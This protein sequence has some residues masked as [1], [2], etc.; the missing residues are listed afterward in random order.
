MKTFTVGRNGE[1]DFDTIN[2]AMERIRMEHK[3]QIQASGLS[4]YHIELMPG[5]YEEKI[6]VDVPGVSI[7]GIDAAATVITYGDYA[8]MLLPDGKPYGTFRTATFKVDADDFM[9]ENITFV[10][11]AGNG[12]DF[13]QAVAVH[14]QG[15]RVIFRNCR[16]LAHQDTLYSGPRMPENE[17]SIP[18]ARQYFYKC[19]IAGDV[20]FIFGASTAFFEECEIFSGYGIIEDEAKIPEKGPD[21]QICGY[22]TATRTPEGEKYGFVFSRCRFTSDCPERTVYLGRPWRNFAKTVLTDCVLGNHIKPEG[23][24]DWN[25]LDARKTTF[26]AEYNSMADVSQRADWTHILSDAEAEEYKREAVL[27]GWDIKK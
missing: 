19:Y 17:D 16:M 7:A 3:S 1:Y 2:A 13:G 4:H 18:V 12:R 11:S 9:A 6:L 21:D 10:N 20:D 24:H 5:T 14:A 26:Y 27:A 23:W 8:R 22:V 25:K 15:D